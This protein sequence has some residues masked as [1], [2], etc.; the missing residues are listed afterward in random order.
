M[1]FFAVALFSGKITWL[2]FVECYKAR[3]IDIEMANTTYFHFDG[4]P[5]ELRV[6]AE[7]SLD[8]EKICVRC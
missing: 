2:P 1:P 3:Q 8:H 7:V 6:P 4:E 5:G